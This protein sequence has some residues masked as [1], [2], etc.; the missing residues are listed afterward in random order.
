MRKKKKREGQ[1]NKEK[2]QDIR[3]SW[4]MN[5]GD[6]ILAFLREE[7]TTES[8]PGQPIDD[9]YRRYYLSLS[10]PFSPYGETL[11][12]FL[13]PRRDR[14]SR[15]VEIGAG[16]GQTC[17]QFAA[18]GWNT[19]AVD[20]WDRQFDL[21]SK[22][23]RRLAPLNLRIEPLKASYPEE[24]S[25]LF[26]DSTVAFFL[27]TGGSVPPAHQNALL[28]TLA[29]AGA[30]VIDPDRFFRMPETADADELL[31]QIQALGFADP[32]EVWQSAN[33]DFLKMRLLYMERIGH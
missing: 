21:M 25:G 16:I 14:F 18:A 4:P 32:V 33:V 22:L 11:I 30:I 27:G 20:K 24:A 13:E 15:I 28:P 6:E 29:S 10:R 7:I 12:A 3:Y 1:R 19:V 2:K 8:I 26:T 23:F 17:L 9:W 5:L 31:R